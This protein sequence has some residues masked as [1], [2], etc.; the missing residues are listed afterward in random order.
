MAK[1]LARSDKRL[2]MTEK[3]NTKREHRAEE[4]SGE[5]GLPLLNRIENARYLPTVLPMLLLIAAALLPLEGWMR[6]AAYAVPAL[7][8][9]APVLPAAVS[10]IREKRFFSNENLTLAAGIL[11]F[12]C[13]LYPE[14]VLLA[15]LFSGA[16]LLESFLLS[17]S[18]KAMDAVFGMLPEKAYVVGENGPEPRAPQ[19]VMPGDPPCVCGRAHSA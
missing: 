5:G 11:L 17:D 19:D 9:F 3:L 8:A 14:A 13:G 7:I 12:S 16:K 15:V 10:S 6:P 2:L 1:H 18:R 4:T